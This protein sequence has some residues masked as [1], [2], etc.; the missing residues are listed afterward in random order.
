MFSILN[1]CVKGRPVAWLSSEDFCMGVM[2]L[3]QQR[4]CRISLVWHFQGHISLRISYLVNYGYSHDESEWTFWSIIC[5]TINLITLKTRIIVSE[6][7]RYRLDCA[8]FVY[9]WQLLL[10]FA[11]MGS[12]QLWIKV[13]TSSKFVRISL[14]DVFTIMF[15][16]MA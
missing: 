11:K 1:K 15:I 13:K 8:V 7:E 12:Q 2:F 3:L 14:T 5:I 9:E 10:R 6:S 4:L 16:S